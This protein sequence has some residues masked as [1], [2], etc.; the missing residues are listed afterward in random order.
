MIGYNDEE[1]YFLN[2]WWDATVILLSQLQNGVVLLLN[3]MSAGRDRKPLL[4]LALPEYFANEPELQHL[5][6]VVSQE[7]RIEE[8]YV[9]HTREFLVAGLI[10]RHYFMIVFVTPDSG[11]TGQESRLIMETQ[12]PDSKYECSFMVVSKIA[13]QRLLYFSQ[14]FFKDKITDSN[15]IYKKDPYAPDFHWE[16]A[17]D[18]MQAD[19]G[20]YYGSMEDAL[21]ELVLFFE[22]NSTLTDALIV[23]PKTSMRNVLLLMFQAY[24]YKVLFYL[25]PYCDDVELFLGLAVYQSIEITGIWDRFNSTVLNLLPFF[26]SKSD[27]SVDRKTAGRIQ[28]FYKE[29]HSVIGGAYD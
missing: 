15:C 20:S 21:A 17:I 4:L 24:A 18:D 11:L 19:L 16:R 23:L 8:M 1:N 12:L 13:A 5:V 22:E 3:Y 10:K 6:S 28:G 2:N 7:P 9:Y 25:D 26:E 27:V 14:P 29:L